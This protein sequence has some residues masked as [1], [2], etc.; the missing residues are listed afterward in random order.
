MFTQ[1]N[2]PQTLKTHYQFIRGMLGIDQWKHL[3]SVLMP[4]LATP[5]YHSVWV[6]VS[7]ILESTLSEMTM[8]LSSSKS[9]TTKEPSSKTIPLHPPPESS[10]RPDRSFV[11]ALV[12]AKGRM[13][14]IPG[15][16]RMQLPQDL[17]R[18]YRH[19]DPSMTLADIH[20]FKQLAWAYFSQFSLKD[21]QQA[22]EEAVFYDQLRDIDHYADLSR[23][24]AAHF[25]H[26]ATHTGA[27]EQ[28]DLWVEKDIWY[29]PSPP[30]GPPSPMPSLE[31]A[32]SSPCD[33]ED[34]LSDH[35]HRSWS[36]NGLSTCQLN[37]C[38]IEEE[39]HQ[40]PLCETCYYSN[41]SQ[42]NCPQC[43][44]YLDKGPQRTITQQGRI[45]YGSQDSP[46]TTSKSVEVKSLR[47][48]GFYN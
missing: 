2:L 10:W 32:A 39:S 26:I 23:G 33:S 22:V 8:W 48:R 40:C 29:N 41:G 31:A 9:G 36:R 3:L 20:N 19:A 11:L 6:Q 45:C 4:T 13:W 17:W 46:K 44:M 37:N 7:C 30:Q 34:K 38:Q 25:A 43:S 27:P 5:T 12:E 16:Y 47:E 35:P 21:F 18:K 1:L 42:V 24:A 28:I 14:K 15:G